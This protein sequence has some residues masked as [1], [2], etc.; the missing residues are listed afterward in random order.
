M[1]ELETIKNK[2]LETIENLN[3]DYFDSVTQTLLF[4]CTARLLLN[5]FGISN[6]ITVGILDFALSF[7]GSLQGAVTILQKEKTNSALTPQQYEM[8]LKD[9]N[10]IYAALGLGFHATNSGAIFNYFLPIMY[11]EKGKLYAF[12]AGSLFKALSPGWGRV[13][14]DYNIRT[15]TEMRR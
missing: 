15:K 13:F 2:Y 12:A 6:P 5:M 9:S 14:E 1:R 10:K 4:Y 7:Q 8:L 11:G 3:N